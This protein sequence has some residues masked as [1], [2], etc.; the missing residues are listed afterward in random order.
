[1]LRSAYYAQ[2]LLSTFGTSIGEVAL[3]PATGG[4][5]QIDLTYKP[6]QIEVGDDIHTK[7]VV[8]W[9]RKAEGGF[10]ETKILKQRLRN[11]IEP[12]KNLGHSDTPSSKAQAN[13]GD[14]GSKT[15]V[16]AGSTESVTGKTA[17]NL[18]GE[19]EDCK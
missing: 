4:F 10:P 17:E 14:A 3:T 7:E 1:M 8:L 6:A 2:E 5:F 19:C 9:D 16:E 18:A 13:N 15:S 12:E 11:Y